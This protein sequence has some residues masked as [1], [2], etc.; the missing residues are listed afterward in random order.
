MGLLNTLQQTQR[1]MQRPRRIYF[2]LT[3]IDFRSLIIASLETIGMRLVARSLDV[4][5]GN[6]HC[7]MGLKNTLLQKHSPIVPWPKALLEY[8]SN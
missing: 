2:K 1:P 3:R 7:F 8:T 6:I 5:S 4:L